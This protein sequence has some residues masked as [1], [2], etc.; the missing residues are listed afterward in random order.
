MRRWLKRAKRVRVHL[1]DQGL[2]SIEGLLLSKRSREYVLALPMLITSAEG[3]P[4]EL[5]SKLLVIPRDR[6]AFYEVIR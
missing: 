3:E 1:L 4:A 5:D 2:P 6:V